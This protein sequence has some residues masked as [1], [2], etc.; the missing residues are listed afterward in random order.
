MFKRDLVETKLASWKT[1]L[2]KL[3]FLKFL[4]GTDKLCWNL[5]ENGKFLVDVQSACSF[6]TITIANFF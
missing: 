2:G 4:Q 3:T 1:L 6:N 5:H